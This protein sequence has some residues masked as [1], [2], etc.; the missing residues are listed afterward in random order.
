M[1]ILQIDLSNII[2]AALGELLVLLI[3]LIVKF[4]PRKFFAE[5]P[6]KKAW[7]D[8]WVG[9]YYFWLQRPFLIYI[10]PCS[11]I[12]I[13]LF[14]P[15]YTYMNRYLAALIWCVLG[16]AVGIAHEWAEKGQNIKPVRPSDI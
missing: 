7:I 15:S 9:S 16:L 14:D 4:K 12:A 5:N 6:K 3:V 1:E 10:I 2:N 13:S 8:Y 11:M